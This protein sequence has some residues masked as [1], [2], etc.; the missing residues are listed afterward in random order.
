MGNRLS[1]IYTRTGDTGSTGLA[2]GS[3][4]RKSDP[5]VAAMGCVD[6]LNSVLGLLRCETLSATLDAQLAHIQHRLF[7]L[8]GELSLPGER[9]LA[10][11]DV[12]QLEAWLDECNRELAPLKDF[13]LPG[14][15]RPAALCH[16]ARAVC[17]RAERR[18]WE[19]AGDGEVAPALRYLNRLSDLL[20]VVARRL[21]R[22][23]GVEDVLWQ[24][25]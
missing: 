18:V 2:D 11:P 19:L 17:R 13:I 25:D 15:N 3:R 16:L 6:E 12:Q 1:R 24:R 8:G 4:V 22:D 9:I 20:F 14:G 21:N 5:R 7:D 23:A 10:D